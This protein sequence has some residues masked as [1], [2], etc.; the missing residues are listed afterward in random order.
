MPIDYAPAPFQKIFKLEKFLPNYSE[1]VLDWNIVAWPDGTLGLRKGSR[2]ISSPS[3]WMVAA[4]GLGRYL[5]HLSTSQK[6]TEFTWN[7]FHV[8]TDWVHAYF[9]AYSFNSVLLFE[10]G[11]AKRKAY[12]PSLLQFPGSAFFASSRPIRPTSVMV[13]CLEKTNFM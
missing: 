9:S 7:K 6:E 2:K 3:A 12:H 5:A 11:L 8:F 13:K 1:D 4:N 10:Q